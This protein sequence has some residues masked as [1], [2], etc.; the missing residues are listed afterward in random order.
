[1]AQLPQQLTGLAHLVMVD[2]PSFYP[3]GDFYLNSQ[4]L[5]SLEEGRPL[6]YGNIGVFHPTLFA[7][8]QKK[9]FEMREVLRPAIAAQAIS[10]EHFTG[11]WQNIGTTAQLEALNSSCF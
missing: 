10:A 2:N 11:Q 3:Q 5:L 4:G 1:F 7:Q 6:T 9:K 8:A